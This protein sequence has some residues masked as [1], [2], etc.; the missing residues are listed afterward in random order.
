[1][2]FLELTEGSV[3]NLCVL[4]NFRKIFFLLFKRILLN[5]D[6]KLNNFEEANVFLC[7]KKIQKLLIIV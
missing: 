5:R 2:I 7:L 1:M 6:R 3:K 4:K